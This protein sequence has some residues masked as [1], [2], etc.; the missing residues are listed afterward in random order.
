MFLCSSVDTGKLCERQDALATTLTSAPS[1]SL[2]RTPAIANTTL[3]GGRR[4]CY[5]VVTN[6]YHGPSETLCN[7]LRQAM[8]YGLWWHLT[9]LT[10]HHSSH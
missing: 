9:S 8:N 1:L 7:S 4:S 10:R 5:G 2:R 6:G 3:C